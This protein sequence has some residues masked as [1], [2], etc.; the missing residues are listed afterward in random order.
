MS[1]LRYVQCLFRHQGLKGL[2]LA[3]PYYHD[4][5]Y[6]IHHFVLLLGLSRDRRSWIS[7]PELHGSLRCGREWEAAWLR[8]DN[9][10]CSWSLLYSFRSVGSTYYNTHPNE[11]QGPKDQRQRYLSLP[12]SF[13]LALLHKKD[14]LDEHL[15]KCGV[16]HKT[17]V[18]DDSGAHTQG[19]T[20][21]STDALRAPHTAYILANVCLPPPGKNSPLKCRDGSL[22]ESTDLAVDGMPGWRLRIRQD[23]RAMG[24]H[25][26]LNVCEEWDGAAPWGMWFLYK[27]VSFAM[28]RLSFDEEEALRAVKAARDMTR[29]FNSRNANMSRFLFPHQV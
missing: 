3:S 7:W 19:M 21:T 28:P 27:G 11:N 9:T 22:A 23:D 4:L 16:P 20:L 14:A 24:P 1:T 13:T 6:E 26:F 5:P 25:G 15:S 2:R 29:R 10:V 12:M 17:V 8:S 18:F